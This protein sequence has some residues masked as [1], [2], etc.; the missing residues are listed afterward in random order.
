MPFARLDNV[1]LFYTDEG[2]G[3]PPILFVHGYSCDSHDWSWQIPY[4][5]ESH[6]VVA[7]DLRGH[8]HSSVPNHGY[9]HRTFCSGHRRHTILESIGCGPVVAISHSLGA[10]IVSTLAVKRPD[11][12]RAVVS[13]DPG[14]PPTRRDRQGIGPHARR[15]GLARADSCSNSYRGR[16]LHSSVRGCTQ[17]L[18][19]SAHGR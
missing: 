17:D 14:I 5:V 11:L 8:G 13:I 18:A 16:P 1:T 2:S 7:I 9:D 3:E 12:V 10:V 19:P 15:F 6:R 4:F